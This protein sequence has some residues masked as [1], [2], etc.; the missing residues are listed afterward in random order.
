MKIAA[1]VL[2][3]PPPSLADNEK[4][5]HFSMIHR[6]PLERVL[7]VSRSPT[8]RALAVAL[9]LPDNPTFIIELCNRSALLHALLY[10]VVAALA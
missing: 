9:L 3:L 5:Y 4:R 7:G 8:P 2:P 6:F 10:R 1:R